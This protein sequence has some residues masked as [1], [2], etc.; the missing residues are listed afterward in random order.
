[1]ALKH[2]KLLTDEK[3]TLILDVSDMCVADMYTVHV[4]HVVHVV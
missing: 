1:M 3:H 4:V 2:D